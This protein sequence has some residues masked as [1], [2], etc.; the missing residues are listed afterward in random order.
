MHSLVLVLS[1]ILH[2]SFFLDSSTLY[3]YFA[4]VIHRGDHISSPVINYYSYFT[5][6]HTKFETGQSASF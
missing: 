4:G 6:V 3:H 5:H 2:I 1:K